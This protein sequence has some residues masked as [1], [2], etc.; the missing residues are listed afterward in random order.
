MSYSTD[1]ADLLAKQL[2]RFT[3]LNR[4]QLAGQFANLDF[5]LGEVH[6]ALGVIDGYGVRFTQMHAAQEQHVTTQGTTEFDLDKD[7]NTEGRAS[8]PR[9]VPGQ[10]LERARRNLS[11]AATRF[12]DRC[13]SEGL[14]TS[15]QHSAAVESLDN[16]HG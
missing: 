6:H 13:H 5:W 10:E 16:C 14:L 7:W 8:P 12:L 4:H 1:I 9:R 2:S 11:Q 3:T 15:D